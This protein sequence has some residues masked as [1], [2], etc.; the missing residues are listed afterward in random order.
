VLVAR[1]G[2]DESA[3]VDIAA[4]ETGDGE[5]VA[6]SRADETVEF[7]AITGKSYDI[8]VEMN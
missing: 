1:V 6:L 3:A 7:R 5:P 8:A 4:V 2:A